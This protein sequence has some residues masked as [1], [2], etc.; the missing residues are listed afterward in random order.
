M[1]QWLLVKKTLKMLGFDSEEAKGV[2][3]V[4]IEKEATVK[5]EKNGIEFEGNIKE[6]S[7]VQGIDGDDFLDGDSATIG[8]III[9]EGSKT[10]MNSGDTLQLTF[11]SE[12][13]VVIP[14]TDVTVTSSKGTVIS[15]NATTDE[16]LAENTGTSTVTVT[17]N[18]N[19]EVFSKI[20][21]KV[22]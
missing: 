20:K 11:V 4:E 3:V 6:S 12:D 22:V 5:F 18:S 8:R 1:K 19:S 14:T 21:I 13:G 2:D 16:L 7:E 15:V 17:L 9:N 10:T